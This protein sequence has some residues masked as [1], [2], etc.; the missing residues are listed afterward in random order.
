M[1]YKVIKLLKRKEESKKGEIIKKFKD[2][3]KAYIT[4]SSEVN[5]IK[6]ARK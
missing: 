4:Q 6:T 1:Q 2:I 3:Q 5:K